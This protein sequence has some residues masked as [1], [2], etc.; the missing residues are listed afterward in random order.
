MFAD[1]MV[2]LAWDVRGTKDSS[3]L[4]GIYNILLLMY[5]L[6][7]SGLPEIIR[8]YNFSWSRSSGKEKKISAKGRNQRKLCEELQL[9]LKKKGRVVLSSDWLSPAV[10][11][12]VCSHKVSKACL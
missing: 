3:F 10:P 7:K 1:C 9:E 8:P 6:R 2:A 4:G 12:L 11:I 5:F